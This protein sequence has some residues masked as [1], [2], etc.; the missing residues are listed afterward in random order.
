MPVLGRRW[1]VGGATWR[2]ASAAVLCAALAAGCGGGSKPIAREH[3]YTPPSTL[4]ASPPAGVSIVAASDHTSPHAS[5]ATVTTRLR[6]GHRT[7]LAGAVFGKAAHRSGCPI[8]CNP[9]VWESTRTGW[10]TT[11]KET[12]SGSIADEHLLA[13]PT[14]ILLFNSDEGTALWRSAGGRHWTSQRLPARM[15]SETVKRLSRHGKTIEARMHIAT[16]GSQVWTLTIGAHWQRQ[17]AHSIAFDRSDSIWTE[18]PN[19]SDKA[20]LPSFPG[21]D[22]QP[23][24]SADGTHL[25]FSNS[26][27]IIAETVATGRF[28]VVTPRRD[29]CRPAPAATSCGEPAWSPDGRAI[30]FAATTAATTS[31]IKI[32]TLA[33]GKVR[34]LCKGDDPSW[35]PDG[36][37]IAFDRYSHGAS[38]V[39][40]VRAHGRPRT[41]RLSPNGLDADEPTYSS[42][43]HLLA[44][45]VIT[46]PP[47]RNDVKQDAY[48][49][50]LSLRSGRV[51]R[52]TR[53]HTAVDTHPAFS[54]SG[55]RLA[56]DRTDCHRSGHP[57]QCSDHIEVI[58]LDGHGRRAGARTQLPRE[59]ADPAWRP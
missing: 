21:L 24:W 57:Y 42:H 55:R 10:R 17:H 11:L 5:G 40:S 30:A 56:F 14:S 41:R 52:L 36:E 20:R 15:R 29:N 32:V 50:V 13:T 43:G 1:G 8:G 54:P 38:K 58:H 59:A 46:R 28:T 4:P 49:A 23:A 34:T 25:A 47:R 45:T 31:R 12:A 48:L 26:Y 18:R 6:V 2:A 35:S 51:H 7:L 39:M 9:V 3:A 53:P 22:Q 33:T 44:F 37:R 19:G 16:G 27:E